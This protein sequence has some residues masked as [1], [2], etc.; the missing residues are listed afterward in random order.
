[1]GRRESPVLCHPLARALIH[2]DLDSKALAWLSSTAGAH[3]LCALSFLGSP[4]EGILHFHHGLLL[5]PGVDSPG[6]AMGG[7]R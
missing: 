1:M 2:R 3:S 4:L 5:G 7:H 6:W